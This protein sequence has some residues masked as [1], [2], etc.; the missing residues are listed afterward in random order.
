MSLFHPEFRGIA[1]SEKIHRRSMLLVW[2][3]VP[4]QKTHTAQCIM[5]IDV[6][7]TIR[8]WTLFV[9]VHADL[10]TLLPLASFDMIRFIKETESPISGIISAINKVSKP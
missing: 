8:K 9:I 2:F 3:V 6:V 7:V 4:F 10:S 5:N 1:R